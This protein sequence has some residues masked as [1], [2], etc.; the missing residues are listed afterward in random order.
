MN[1]VAGDEKMQFEAS[2]AKAAYAK[3]KFKEIEGNYR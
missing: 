2:E 1:K 3:E